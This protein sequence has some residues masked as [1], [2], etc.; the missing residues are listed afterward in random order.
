[1]KRWYVLKKFIKI[2]KHCNELRSKLMDIQLALED[3]GNPDSF[4]DSI[5]NNKPI[6]YY[7]K[8]SNLDRRKYLI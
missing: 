4:L 5:E 1:M 2:E 6:L 3:K 7:P 8:N